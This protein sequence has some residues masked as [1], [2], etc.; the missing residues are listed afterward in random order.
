ME[1]NRKT[2]IYKAISMEHI[3][4]A[5]YS[6]LPNT[7]IVYTTEQDRNVIIRIYL[8]EKNVYERV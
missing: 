1:L 6:V 4:E 8:K 7:Y 3:V 5:V 2:L